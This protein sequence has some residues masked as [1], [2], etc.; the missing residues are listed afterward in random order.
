MLTKVYFPYL[1]VK[2]TSAFE[3]LND[4]KFLIH[5]FQRNFTFFMAP[6]FSVRYFENYKVEPY[7]LFYFSCIGMIY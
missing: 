7:G 6:N 3:I 4:V 1:V 2:T 5:F